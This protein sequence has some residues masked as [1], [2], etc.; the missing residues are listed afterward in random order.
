MCGRFTLTKS[1]FSEVAGLLDASFDPAFQQQFQPRFNIAPTDTHWI[2]CIA[3]Q[4]VELRPSVW[5]LLPFWS[6]KPEGFINARVETIIEKP[7]FKDAFKNR[8]CV[9]PADGFYEWTG[10]KAPKQPYWFHLPQTETFLFAGLFEESRSKDREGILTSFTILTTAAG[11]TVKPYHQR[12]PI[13]ISPKIAKDW[14]STSPPINL[15]QAQDLIHL[16]TDIPDIP[17]EAKAVSKKVNSP[18]VDDPTC[19]EAA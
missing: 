5:G 16:V 9:I 13:I 7:A 4:Q 14:V 12:M 11:G 17:L 1:Q 8:R 15:K 3:N 2:F 18:K 6:K 10:S 19:I